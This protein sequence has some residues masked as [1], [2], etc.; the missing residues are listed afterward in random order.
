MTEM[1]FLVTANIM[2]F[3]KSCTYYYQKMTEMS[4]FVSI[5]L[6]FPLILI[7]YL[8]YVKKLTEMSFFSF[9]RF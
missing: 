3:F 7:S 4:F 1:S 2:V 6:Y 9:G 8:F 5:H